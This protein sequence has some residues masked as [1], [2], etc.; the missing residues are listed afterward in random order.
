MEENENEYVELNERNIVIRV[1]ENTVK[2][3]LKCRVYHENELI[4]AMRE[5]EMSEV[6]DAF[7]LAD[8][9]YDDPDVR[10]AI[11]DKGM[12][13]LDKL[14]NNNKFGDV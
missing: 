7:R 5:L 14:D 4:D 13:Y 10:Y 2:I 6:Q 8:E 12:E 11:T 1:P 9:Y 3:T